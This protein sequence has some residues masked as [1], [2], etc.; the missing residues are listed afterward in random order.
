[1]SVIDL[2]TFTKMWQSQESLDY[3]YEAQ[4][5]MRNASLH[6]L[7]FWE[8]LYYYYSTDFK[9]A[10]S[11]TVLFE[12]YDFYADCV[13]RHI[14]KDNIALQVLK[15]D[16]EIESWT[17][18][19][20]HHYV[21]IQA[22]DWIENH[23]VEPGQTVALHLPYGIHFIVALMTALRLGLLI[24]VIPIEDR[25]WG[26]KTL[27]EVLDHVKPD[28]VVTEPGQGVKEE[29]NPVELDLGLERTVAPWDSHAYLSSETVQKHFNPFGEEKGCMTL[30]EATRSYLIPMRDSL[31]AL[32]LQ[33][34][35]VWARPLASMR[36]EEPSATLM[37]LFAGATIF[38]VPDYLIQSN[39]AVLKDQPIEVLGISPLL[40]EL[41]LK[42]PRAPSKQLKIWYRSPLYGNDLSWKAFIELNHLQKIPGLCLLFEYEKGG[43]TLLSQPKPFKFPAFIRPNFGSPWKLLKLNQKKEL[44]TEGFGLFHVEPKSSTD[45]YLVLSQVGDEWTV[46]ASLL[47]LKEGFPYPIRSIESIVKKLDFVQSCMVLPERDPNHYIQQRFVL[48]IFVSPQE[49]HVLQQKIDVWTHQV[50]ELIWNQA[51]EV[52]IPDQIVFYPLYPKMEKGELQ[53]SWVESQYRSGRLFLKRDRSIYHT[54]NLLKQA[55]YENLPQG[56]V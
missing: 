6:P 53:R 51:G 22:A 32:Q 8:N 1:M 25:F 12:K 2:E 56:S 33:K 34:G 43:V 30:I 42:M 44:A 5:W 46:S 31:I 49:R 36:L 26:R 24:C 27:Y 47:P 7:L 11:Q 9:T 20:I 18:S 29:W 37:A 52:F 38:H 3:R 23:A 39:P 15:S 35:T 10:S 28:L 13:V 41:W 21:G 55:V 40:Q 50:H 14:A 17:Y 54:L 4:E 45:P 16:K 19:Q 48:L